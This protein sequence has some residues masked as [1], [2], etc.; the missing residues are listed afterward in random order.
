MGEQAENEFKDSMAKLYLEN[1]M[2]AKEVIDLVQ[3]A[4]RAGI[5]SV[6][7]MAK[8]GGEERGWS[9]ASRNLLAVLLKDLDFPALYWAEIPCHDPSTSSDRVLQWVPLLLPPRSSAPSGCPGARPGGVC[10]HMVRGQSIQTIS[11]GLL[12]EKEAP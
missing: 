4:Y 5:H 6:G 2:S 9:N 8:A 12:C 10:Q 1:K 7:P 11:G 3:R